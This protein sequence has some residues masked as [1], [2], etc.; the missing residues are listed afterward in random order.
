MDFG[1]TNT[2]KA[3]GL[4]PYPYP[5]P[6]PFPQVAAAALRTAGLGQYVDHIVYGI[7]RSGAMQEAMQSLGATSGQVPADRICR[8]ARR[9]GRWGGFGV[10]PLPQVLVLTAAPPGGSGIVATV[11]PFGTTAASPTPPVSAP[12][13]VH[14]IRRLTNGRAGRITTATTTTA[15]QFYPHSYVCCLSN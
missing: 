3:D 6:P 2:C 13:P 11:K 14:H 9:R 8:M 10:L 12:Q 15:A 7:S 5:F 1:T 4:K